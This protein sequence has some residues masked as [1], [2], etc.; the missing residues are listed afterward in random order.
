MCVVDVRDVAELHVRAMTSPEAAA[1]RLVASADFFWMRQIADL[2]RD[3]L[4]PRA[5]GIPTRDLPDFV[6][7]ALAWFLPTLRAIPPMIGRELHFSSEKARRLLGFSP[8]PARATILECA[9]SLLA[10]GVLSGT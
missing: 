5:K 1:Q 3:G 7:R 8:R 4:G 6:V 10:A 2:L 9:E